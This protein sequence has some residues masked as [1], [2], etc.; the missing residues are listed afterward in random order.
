MTTTMTTDAMITMTMTTI[1]IIKPMSVCSLELRIGRSV[2]V[3]LV[4]GT[5]SSVPVPPESL[6]GLP[7]VV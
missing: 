1:P 6:I 5:L 4:V 2:A 7:F 3:S